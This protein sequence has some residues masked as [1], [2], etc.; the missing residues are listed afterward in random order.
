MIKDNKI[1]EKTPKTHQQILDAAVQVFAKKGY[2]D[3]R[4][5]DI[6]EA[7]GKSKGAV[8][9]HFNSKEE[10][11]LSVIDRF[12]SYL[13]EGLQKAIESQDSGID[14]VDAA[15]EACLS[16][17]DRYRFLAKIFLVQSTGLGKLIEEKRIEINDRFANIIR[18][19]LDQA[20]EDGDIPEINTEVAALAWIGAIYEVVIRW[21]LT[22]HPTPE[23]TLPALR[24]FLLRSIGVSEER[25]QKLQIV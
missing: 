21:V 24:S 14:K 13:H 9:F 11:F 16:I 18:G 23:V 2:H 3:S 1:S 19:Y 8:Y 20:V 25:L 7:A 6:V 22:G 17:F 10:I 15:L 5:D 4:V 12:E